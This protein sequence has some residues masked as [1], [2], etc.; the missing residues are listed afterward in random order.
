MIVVFLVAISRVACAESK[1]CFSLTTLI[2]NLRPLSILSTLYACQ[3][4]S[5]RCRLE[6]H[7][8]SL[9]PARVLSRNRPH[10]PIMAIPFDSN[11]IGSSNM[12][13]LILTILLTYLPT[14]VL[15]ANTISN[16][17]A[18]GTVNIPDPPSPTGNRGSTEIFDAGARLLLLHGP[19]SDDPVFRVAQLVLR[20]RQGAKQI[21]DINRQISPLAP[22]IFAHIDA[23]YNARRAFEGASENAT[24]YDDTESARALRAMRRLVGWAKRQSAL[25]FLGIRVPYQKLGAI[26]SLYENVDDEAASALSAELID[27]YQQIDSRRE[28]AEWLLAKVN[29]V[30][31]MFDSD[32]AN[33]REAQ[34]PSVNWR[35]NPSSLPLVLDHDTYMNDVRPFE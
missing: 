25:L 12:Q 30:L 3:R 2:S 15:A 4:T 21:V 26:G 13:L 5:C 18:S 24:N 8:L 27:D 10:S 1:Q 16:L 14:Y 7:Y 22:T 31:W 20:G 9:I 35:P 33:A 34:F 19:L 6:Q 29:R 32:R 23:M 11:P 28:A 17:A